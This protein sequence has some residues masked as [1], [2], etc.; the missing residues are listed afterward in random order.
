MKELAD[1]GGS[2]VRMKVSLNG[3]LRTTVCRCRGTNT[4]FWRFVVDRRRYFQYFIAS[5]RKTLMYPQVI[6]AEKKVDLQTVYFSVKWCT[7]TD[8]LLRCCVCYAMPN[9]IQMPSRPIDPTSVAV[10]VPASAV[11][12]AT[13]L[14]R[15]RHRHRHHLHPLRLHHLHLHLPPA[16]SQLQ[17]PPPAPASPSRPSSSSLRPRCPPIR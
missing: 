10:V 2:L 5:F 6:L 14:D 12:L 17:L 16:R 13:M 15:H 7:M 3:C 1:L 8:M 9:P 11:P 4:C